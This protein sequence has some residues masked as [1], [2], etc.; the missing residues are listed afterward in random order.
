MT[1]QTKPFKV[2]QASAGSGKT[3]TIVKEYLGLCLRNE[4][5]TNNY[6]HIL[7]ITFTNKAANEM[8]K[9]IM[10]HLN[11]IINSNMSEQPKDMEA[12]LIRELNIDRISL[13]NNAKLL[14]QKI[15][16]DYSSFC[17]STIDAFFQKVSRSFAKDLNLPAEFNVSIDED[18]IADAITEHLG[19]QLGPNEPFLTKIIEDYFDIVF[20][21]ESKPAIADNIHSFVLTLFKEDTFQRNEQNQFKTQ[22]QYDETVKFFY[23]EFKEFESSCQ[24][25]VQK[26]NQFVTDNNLS[27]ADFNGKSKN[28]CISLCNKLQEKKYELFT[29]TQL[30]VFESNNKWFSTTQ[31]SNLTVGLDDLVL[32]FFSKYKQELP[33]YLFYK[34]QIKKLSFYALRSIIKDEI[35]NYIGETTIVPI[36]EFNKRIND[37]LGDFSVP[38]IYERM[39]EQFKNI[40]IDEFQDTSVLQWQN[41]IPLVDN[42]LSNQNLNI[43]VGDGK[44]SIYRWRNGEVNQIVSLPLVYKKPDGAPVFEEMEQNFINNYSFD[45]L[46][47]NYRSFKNIVKFNNEYFSYCSETFLPEEVKAVYCGGEDGIHKALK[48][49]QETHKKGEGLVQVELFDPEDKS[50]DAMLIRIKELIGEL[51]D[52]GFH[53]SDIAILVRKNKQGSLT[54]NYLNQEGIE[55]ISPEAILL[56]SSEKVLLIISTLNYLINTNNEVAIADVLFH[57]NITHNI[58]FKGDVSQIFSKVNDIALGKSSIEEQMQIEPDLLQSLMSNAY[59]LYDLCSALIR[60]YGFNSLGDSFLN[61][62]LDIVYKWQSTD[63]YGIQRFINFWEKKKSSLSI[64]TNDTDAVNIMTIH[65]SKG[66]EFPVVIYPFV[67]D[68][69]SPRNDRQFWFTAEE[70]GLKPIPNVAKVQFSFSNDR[71]KWN[72]QIP[73]LRKEENDKVKLD[74]MN[75]SYVAFTR[76]KQR[77]YIMTKDSASLDTSPI[78]AFLKKNNEKNTEMGV[79]QIANDNGQTWPVIYRLGDPE[80]Q[81]VDEKK[82]EEKVIGFFN[83]SASGDWLNKINVEPTPSMFWMTDADSFEPREWGKLVHKILSE[84]EY[85][86]DI[87]KV[88]QTYFDNGTID[89]PTAQMLKKT[90]QKI[91]GNSII[92]EAFSSQA[93]VKNECELLTPEETKRP[94]RYAELPDKIYLLDYKTGQPKDDDIKQLA[95]Y[96]AILQTIVSKNILAYLVYINKKENIDVKPIE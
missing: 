41:I 36:S 32:P 43:I 51:L 93:K 22:E 87:D 78:N 67:L 44:Q 91:V 76:P 8:K 74:Q 54:A 3:Y 96:K 12:D 21:S 6:T 70:L 39:G 60:V 7:A 23:K 31:P 11:S 75:L 95:E 38:F 26:F 73:K 17:V 27:V 15:I 1:Q 62:L 86:D 80:Q 30:K 55:V 20:D 48:I 69:I 94:D 81:R 35:E 18:E 40:F 10:D 68:N 92:S 52:H 72:M 83:E 71:E 50:D 88:L 13:K 79:T 46:Q 57:W 65:K 49:K 16:H 82:D 85:P 14:F 59:S 84:V 56:K 33:S 19:E 64:V 66:L 34:E 45:E 58:A 2:Y 4:A 29:P 24:Q 61:F 53:K 5:S 89:R 28:A 63:E 37:I 42:N 47:T 90:F 25:F 77:L 9:K